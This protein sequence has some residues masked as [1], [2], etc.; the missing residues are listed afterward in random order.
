MFEIEISFTPEEEAI[1]RDYAA[2][3]G[4]TVEQ[5]LKETLLAAIDEEKE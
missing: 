3:H 4:L 2:S 5:L 1:V